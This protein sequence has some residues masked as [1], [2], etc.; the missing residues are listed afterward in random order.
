MDFY[1]SILESLLRKAQQF[2]KNFTVIDQK[3]LRIIMYL[4]KSILFCDDNTWIIK[5]NHMFGVTMGSFDGGEV[6]ELVG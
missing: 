4:R 5:S 2:A 6:C 1:P 3:S